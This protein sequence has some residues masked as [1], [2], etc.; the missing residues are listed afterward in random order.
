LVSPSPRVTA[1]AKPGRR[2]GVAVH[3]VVISRILA[4]ELRQTAV[5]RIGRHG[6]Q[7]EL[8]TVFAWDEIFEEVEAV[9]IGVLRRIARQRVSALAIHQLNRH[10]RNAGARALGPLIYLFYLS[11]KEK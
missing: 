2:I 5:A 6:V 7:I 3:S 8:D 11:S 9:A 4:R 1:G 10:T